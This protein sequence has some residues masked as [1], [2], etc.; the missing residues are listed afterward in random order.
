M[1]IKKE[2]TI[3]LRC[4]TCGCEDHF[5]YNKDKSYVKCTFCN[6]EYIGGI[7]ELKE[8]NRN[9]FEDA[10]KERFMAKLGITDEAVFEQ[11]HIPVGFDIFNFKF[12]KVVGAKLDNPPFNIF[13][14]IGR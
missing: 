11:I 7:E 3:K 1:G 5:E 13:E 2:Y 14:T 4:A 12:V 9:A 8:H 10:K 6:R